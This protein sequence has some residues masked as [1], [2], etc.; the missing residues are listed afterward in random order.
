MGGYTKKPGGVALMFWNGQSFNERSLEKVGSFKAAHVIYT[1]VS[2]I[3]KKDMN[4]WLRKASTVIWDL[5]GMRRRAVT[6]KKA[7]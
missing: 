6:K 7:A 4:R 5:A 1:D 3:S 2:Q